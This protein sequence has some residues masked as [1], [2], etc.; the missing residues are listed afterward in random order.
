[1]LEDINKITK[2]IVFTTQTGMQTHPSWD[3]H[4]L[5]ILQCSNPLLLIEF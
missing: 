5:Q 1:M 3:R 2:L 4:C